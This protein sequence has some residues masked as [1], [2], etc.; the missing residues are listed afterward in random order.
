VRRLSLLV[1]LAACGGGRGAPDAGR[2]DGFFPV[3]AAPLPDGASLAWIDFAA[4]GCALA[5]TPPA[6]DGGV[7]G[8]TCTGA[9]PLTVTFTPLAS[10]P[11][12]TWA[13][14]FGAVGASSQA[15]P[16]LTF[17]LPGAYD[18]TLAA[19]GPGGS[20]TLTRAGYI[21]VAPAPLGAACRQ[22]PQCASGTCACGDAACDAAAS[23]CAAPC[24]FD[25][26]GVCGQLAGAWGAPYCLHACTSDADCPPGR[27]C[28]VIA[29]PGGGWIDACVPA[30]V[31]RPIGDSCAAAAP[32][33]LDDTLC[34]SDHCL[35][36]GARG[37]CT[38]ACAGVA[39][40][41]TG[42]ACAS[43]TNGTTACLP[44]CDAGHACGDDPWLACEAPGAPGPWGFTLTAPGTVC[45]PKSCAAPADCPGGTCVAGHCTG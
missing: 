11:I 23:L 9:A 37:V 22:G 31:L 45:A 10:G 3:D 2:L 21:V 20:A 39:P 40:C 16:T 35:G 4:S 19:A 33:K 25:C 30:G 44:S 1:V 8:A 41:P 38:L 15:T 29:A 36:I 42:T 32:G 7:A 6:V 26:A 18:V 28:D 12:D 5:A 13:W 43:F 24:G 14:M 17:A 27:A 34:A